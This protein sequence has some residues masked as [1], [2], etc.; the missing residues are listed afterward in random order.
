MA[1]CI[2]KHC[3]PHLSKT[4][5][6]WSN[7]AIAKPPNGQLS[8][9]TVSVVGV[10]RGKHFGSS[11]A[12]PV[13]P[14]STTHQLDRLALGGQRGLDVRPIGSRQNEHEVPLLVRLGRSFLLP[15][16]KQSLLRRQAG[17]V[18][19]NEEQKTKVEEEEEEQR[20]RGV[21]TDEEA[22]AKA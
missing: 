16:A 14:P 20:L 3:D 18:V 5:R 17:E 13:H 11:L 8:L 19:G 15:L 4:I 2:V 7:A 22:K 1:I 9:Q 6:W 10:V 12:F 21:A